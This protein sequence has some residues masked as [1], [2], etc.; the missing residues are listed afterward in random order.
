MREAMQR[1]AAGRTNARNSQALGAY[2]QAIKDRVESNWLR[3]PG[4]RN[5]SCKVRVNQL[6]GGQ[7][8]GFRLLGSCGN[9]AVDRSVEQAIRKSDPLPRAPSDSVFSPEIEFNFEP[10]Q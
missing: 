9:A 4:A 7:I 2:V 10:D 1:E 5:I 6:P 8:T 3:P